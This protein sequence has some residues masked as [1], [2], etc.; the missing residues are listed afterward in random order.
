MPIVLN[1]AIYTGNV[2]LIEPKNSRE[3]LFIQYVDVFIGLVSYGYNTYDKKGAKKELYDY[4]EQKLQIRLNQA[5]KKDAQP[6][7]IFQIKL[8]RDF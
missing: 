3:N 8:D 1:N 7:N 4:A 5:T 6:I 2:K